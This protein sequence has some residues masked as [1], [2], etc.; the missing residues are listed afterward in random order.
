[1]T[2]KPAATVTCQRSRNY[3]RG[4]NLQKEHLHC[5]GHGNGDG[6]K[7]RENGAEYP[8]LDD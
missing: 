2:G 8:V 3:E 1:M 6:R 4:A 7:A 5:R